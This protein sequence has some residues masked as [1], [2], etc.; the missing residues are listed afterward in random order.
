MC[1]TLLG[2]NKIQKH[3]VNSKC[4]VP[5]QEA[6]ILFPTIFRTF[7][8]FSLENSEIIIIIIIII[9]IRHELGFNPYPANV[10][11]MVIS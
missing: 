7:R 3:S 6:L 1:G 8:Q 11:N 4:N 9:I 10:E 5:I 2:P